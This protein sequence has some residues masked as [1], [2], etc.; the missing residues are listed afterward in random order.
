MY[1]LPDIFCPVIYTLLIN[2]S[3]NR[4]RLFVVSI[5]GNLLYEVSLYIPNEDEIT[6]VGMIIVVNCKEVNYA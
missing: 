5:K 3:G 4:S 2:T 1:Q 6:Y